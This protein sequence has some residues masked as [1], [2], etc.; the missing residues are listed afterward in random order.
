MTMRYSRRVLAIAPRE[1]VKLNTHS[2]I[3]CWQIIGNVDLMLDTLVNMYLASILEVQYLRI[4]LHN[5]DNY[6]AS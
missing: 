2:S 5:N 3:N 6:I 4:R 1:M